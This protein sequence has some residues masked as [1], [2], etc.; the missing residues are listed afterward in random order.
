MSTPSPAPTLPEE[1]PAAPLPAPWKPVAAG[2]TALLLL[3]AGLWV[4]Y[5]PWAQRSASAL[6]TADPTLTYIADLDFWQRTPRETLVLANARFD[7][8]HALA[9]IPLQ[10]G[11]WTGEVVPETNQEVL[12]LLDPEQYEQRLYRDADGFPMWL[13]LVGGRSSQP[14]HAPD[15]CYDADGWQY[16]L[17][18]YPVELDGGGEIWGLYLTAQKQIPDPN[19]PGATMPAEHVVFYFYLFPDSDRALE[20]GI[21][22]F[23]LTSSRVGTV[24]ETLA[25]H[26]DFVRQYFTQATDPSGAPP[27]PTAP[28]P[29]ALRP[30]PAL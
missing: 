14:F 22:L 25:R 26:A 5:G 16:S 17:G 10:V 27:D 7:L 11:T 15:I 19:N 8:D 24:E 23:K 6:A 13:S 30:L 4:V 28:P 3:L 12:I 9:D 1:Q 21:V 20:D 2:A 29:Q 18:S